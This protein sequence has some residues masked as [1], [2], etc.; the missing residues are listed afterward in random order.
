MTHQNS[1]PGNRTHLGY[2]QTAASVEGK[3]MLQHCPACKQVQYPHREVCCQ[4]LSD[5]LDWAE[6]D[7]HGT[8][9]ASVPLHRSLE[10]WFQSQLPW[11]LGS[12]KLDCGPVVLA[13][14]SSDACQAGQRMVVTQEKDAAG[15]VV[16]S[17]HPANDKQQNND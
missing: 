3:L 1:P 9:L 4:C 17:A 8:L 16:L 2:A 6:T 15:Q 12:V 14:L 10:P 7:N 5:G 11:L 13:Q